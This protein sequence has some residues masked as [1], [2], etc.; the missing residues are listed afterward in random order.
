MS[1]ETGKYGAVA[2]GHRVTADAAAEILADGGNAFDAAIAAL[3]TACVVEPVLSSPGGGGFLMARPEAGDIA[4]YDFFVDT[5]RR[6]RPQDDI[7]FE[8]ILA[9]FGT[10]TQ[11]FHI[12]AGASAT[13]GFVPGLFRV[14]EELGSLP[15]RRL[16]EPAVRAARESVEITAFQAYLFEVVK[17]ILVWTDDART[18]FEPGGNLLSPGD[19]YGNPDLADVLDEIGREGV[20]F[21]T[22]GELARAML[23]VAEEAG[24]LAADDLTGYRVERRQPVVRRVAGWDIA[25]N[26]PPSMGGALI[27][28]MLTGWDASSK[29]HVRS[30]AEVVD[31]IDRQWRE[32]PTDPSRF[33]A[34]TASPASGL[35]TRGT[36]HVSVADAAG[37]VASTTVSNGEGNGR[38]VPGCGFMLNNMLGEEDLNPAGFHAWKPAMRLAS[39]MA[40]TIAAAS[41]G[42]LIAL[43]SGGSNRIRTAVFQVLINRLEQGLALDDAITAPRLHVEKGHLDFEDLLEPENRDALCAAFPD[44]RAWPETSLYYGGVHAVER[45]KDGAFAGR[46]DPRREGVFVVC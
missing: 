45:S 38:I 16:V 18:L 23:G 32:A 37:N 15:M 22:E 43:G 41:G 8:E 20:R 42:D 4:L 19:V 26:P 27:A 33:V 9:D 25:L 40:P 5:P 11:A 1:F 34:E 2:A 29:P 36:T 44:H 6:K 14:H 35:A 21:A 10:T 30:I 31:R 12:G 28:A 46:G 7:E 13:P 39:M 24:H 3:W 17:P